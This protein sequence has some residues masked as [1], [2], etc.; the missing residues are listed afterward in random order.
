M[1]IHQKNQQNE[2]LH[3]FMQIKFIAIAGSAFA[4]LLDSFMSSEQGIDKPFL[5]YITLLYGLEFF[6]FYSN[7]IFRKFSKDRY[8]FYEY[9]IYITISLVSIIMLASRID[10]EFSAC[11]KWLSICTL[12]LFEKKR[13]MLF[14]YFLFLVLGYL[15][16][17]YW[18]FYDWI[19]IKNFIVLFKFLLILIGF[20]VFVNYKKSHFSRAK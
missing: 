17:S 15:A 4:L 9:L 3:P 7:F 13:G 5:T 12:F 2:Y 19:E 11:F 20:N 18:Y 1:N 6:L 10:Y 16:Y 14:Q 8:I